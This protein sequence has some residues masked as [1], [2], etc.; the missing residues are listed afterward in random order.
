MELLRDLNCMEQMRY[1]LQIWQRIC[2][3][4]AGF[5]H[6]VESNTQILTW[7]A[8]PFLVYSSMRDHLCHKYPRHEKTH[9]F[10]HAVKLCLILMA[11]SHK[12]I[13]SIPSYPYGE[14][15]HSTGL[16]AYLAL[17]VVRLVTP[18]LR[19]PQLRA[20]SFSPH[21]PSWQSLSSKYTPQG[22]KL[23]LPLSLCQLKRETWTK[24]LLPLPCRTPDVLRI[25]N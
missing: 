20:I 9:I 2:W 21:R 11:Q 5:G 7:A 10:L 3:R 16:N 4:F 18:A 8:I 1:S 12:S 13:I 23:V 17:K 6:R 25:E 24:L 19:V 14:I 15:S 22:L